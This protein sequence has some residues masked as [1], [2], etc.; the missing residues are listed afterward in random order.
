MLPYLNVDRDAVDG[1]E[2]ELLG[3][4]AVISNLYLSVDGLRAVDD[5]HQTFAY[6]TAIT[7]RDFIAK[8]VDPGGVSKGLCDVTL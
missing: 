5:D 1:V 6:K 7:A 4:W 2:L 3:E 8:I